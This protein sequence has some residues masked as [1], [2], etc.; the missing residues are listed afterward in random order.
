M[1]S[2]CVFVVDLLSFVFMKFL[3]CAR[4]LRLKSC[5]DRAMIG[6]RFL[7]SLGTV[8]SHSVLI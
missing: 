5:D 1:T 3:G 8:A 4:K 6:R 2:N 7:H